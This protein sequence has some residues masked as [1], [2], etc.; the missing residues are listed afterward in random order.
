[1]AKGQRPKKT[2]Q[3]PLRVEPTLAA[4]I[5]KVARANGLKPAELLREAAAAIVR[6]SER[7]ID[8][9]VP[10][11]MDIRSRYY[12]EPSETNWHVA[13]APSGYTINAVMRESPREAAAYLCGL[14]RGQIVTHPNFVHLRSRPL[15]LEALRDALRLE[16]DHL[17]APPVPKAKP[18][19]HV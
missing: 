13:E 10:K 3:I 2:E 15:F 18:L 5:E 7:T 9:R 19:P 12:P 6:A 16:L 17:A 4:N 1:M 14:F 11:D 8:G